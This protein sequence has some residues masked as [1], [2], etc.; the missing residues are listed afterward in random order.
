MPLIQFNVYFNHYFHIFMLSY[1]SKYSHF[2]KC[3][4]LSYSHLRKCE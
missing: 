2:H 4:Y 3:K 1:I